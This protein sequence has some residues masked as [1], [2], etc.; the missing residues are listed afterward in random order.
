MRTIWPEET[1]SFDGELARFAPLRQWPK[2]L[3]RPH[4]AFL[5]G[6]EGGRSR[7]LARALGRYAALGVDRC[8]LQLPL[9]DELAEIDRLRGLVGR[10]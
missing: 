9:G 10:A 2:P 1:P 6:G 5:V 8:V 3:Q 4:P 7:A